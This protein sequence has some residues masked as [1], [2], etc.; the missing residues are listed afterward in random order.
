MC[1]LVVRA[2][3]ALLLLLLVLVLVL[4]LLMET[5]LR[6]GK[7]LLLRAKAGNEDPASL[8]LFL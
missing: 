6:V 4:A 3:K 8:F 1:L 2:N 7:L 5:S